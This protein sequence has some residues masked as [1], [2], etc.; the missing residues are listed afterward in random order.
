MSWAGSV[1]RLPRRS[2]DTC[3]HQVGTHGLLHA[4]LLREPLVSSAW[5]AIIKVLTQKA[6]E[7]IVRKNMFQELACNP[8]IT[9]CSGFLWPTGEGIGLEGLWVRILILLWLRPS[10]RQLSSVVRQISM[11]FID[12]KVSV[13]CITLLSF[14]FQGRERSVWSFGLCEGPVI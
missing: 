8:C 2:A 11:F 13:F 9:C 6:Q 12:N 1:L 5:H 10:L 14:R 3:N 7:T 4:R